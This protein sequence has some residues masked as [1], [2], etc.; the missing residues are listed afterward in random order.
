[1]FWAENS[2]FS[3]TELFS[4]ATV[5]YRG[6]DRLC[7][8]PEWA[9]HQ[10]LSTSPPF[11]SGPTA[12]DICPKVRAIIYQNGRV[13]GQT[14]RQRDHFRCSRDGT[15]L[16]NDDKYSGLCL[17]FTRHWRSPTYTSK[18]ILLHSKKPITV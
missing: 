17:Q 4:Y 15:D 9:R 5:N 7:V 11:M 16:V 3:L 12:G 13:S 14:T 6:C 2:Q 8:G 18:F 1:M 10:A